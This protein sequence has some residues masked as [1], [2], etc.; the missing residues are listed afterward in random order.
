MPRCCIPGYAGLISRPVNRVGIGVDVHSFAPGRPL[1]IGGVRVPHDQGLL[2][3]S[4]ADVLAHAVADALLGAAALG[5][6]G[7]YYPP[8]EPR[9]K[10]MD[11]M[12]IVRECAERVR[13]A[14]GRI[15]NVDAAIVAQVPKLAP[16][17][18][19]M[20]E[21]LARHLGVAP[22]QVGLKATTSEHLGFTGRKE[23]IVAIAV[24]SVE[25]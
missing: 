6:I 22:G 16:H 17:L 9:C 7:K 2:G 25:I 5:D 3:H 23:G 20:Q 12:I 10:D 11:S 18:P 1:I 8:G 21:T 19:R 15:Q 14:G 13:A 24:A 4:D